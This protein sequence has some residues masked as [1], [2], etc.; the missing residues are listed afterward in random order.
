MAIVMK[1]LLIL[2]IC[3]AG[4]WTATIPARSAEVEVPK[5]HP[6]T[7]GLKVIQYE[8]PRY[9]MTKEDLEQLREAQ[10]TGGHYEK[11]P[12][13]PVIEVEAGTILD[14]GNSTL[15][16]RSGNHGFDARDNWNCGGNVIAGA[17][18][19]GCGT[20]CIS[21][22]AT[23]WSGAVYQDQA[24]NPAPTISVWSGWGCSGY[25][26][27]MGVIGTYA[28]TNTQTSGFVSFIGYHNCG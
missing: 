20:G 8:G 3:L 16:K 15:T 4:V 7:T 26:Q 14:F 11:P 12:G 21:M 18:N 10:R 1:S 17:Y 24:G 28:C 9:E 25:Q 6:D 19:F 22:Y 27:S 5:G 2:W 23:A 13:M